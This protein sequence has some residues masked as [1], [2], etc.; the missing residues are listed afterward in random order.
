MIAGQWVGE[1]SHLDLCDEAFG[2]L[3]TVRQGE[4]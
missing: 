3:Q 4:E 1:R 2:M